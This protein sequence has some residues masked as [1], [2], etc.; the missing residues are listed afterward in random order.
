MALTEAVSDK[1]K[2][3]SEMDEKL[4]TID[5]M[6]QALKEKKEVVK[7]LEARVTAAGENFQLFEAFLG[8]VAG[9]PE[10]EVEEFMKSAPALIN[11]AKSAKYDP[12]L[13]TNFIIGQFTGGAFDLLA[14]GNCGA[15]FVIVK[16]GQQQG[17]PGKKVP[18]IIPEHCPECFA[19][20]NIEVKTRFAETLKQGLEPGKTIVVTKPGKNIQQE[21]YEGKNQKA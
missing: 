2:K 19:F 10:S 7:E 13:L 5:A 6:A 1:E 12:N 11:K 21:K 15:E 4:R 3:V 16:R 20:A 9:R 14:C 17:L 8:L 18:A